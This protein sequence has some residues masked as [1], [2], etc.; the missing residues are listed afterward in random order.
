MTNVL[1]YAKFAVLNQLLFEGTL[2]VKIGRG[3]IIDN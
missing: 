2:L 3:K 1:Q